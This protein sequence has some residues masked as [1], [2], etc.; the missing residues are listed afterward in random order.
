MDKLLRHTVAFSIK[1]PWDTW[2][3][4]GGDDDHTAAG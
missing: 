1:Q 3:H 4:V 2:C